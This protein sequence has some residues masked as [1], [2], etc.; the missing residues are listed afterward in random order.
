[1]EEKLFQV[2]GKKNSNSNKSFFY[3]FF[4]SFSSF[5]IGSDDNTLK[6]W[7]I[8][9]GECIQTLQGHSHA[10]YCVEVF[11]NGRKA[12]SGKKEIKRF[13]FKQII[14]FLSLILFFF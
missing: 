11:E 8:E 5:S 10:V 2:N 6:V 7:D 12:I 14:S 1:M 3:F 9:S 4:H 13:H